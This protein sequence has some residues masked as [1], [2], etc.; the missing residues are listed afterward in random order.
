VTVLGGLARLCLASA[1]SIIA[2]H[3]LTYHLIKVLPDAA[4]RM[5]GLLGGHEPAIT[6]MRARLG[7]RSYSETLRGA[8]VGDFGVSVDGLSV[9]DAVGIQ[10]LETLPR[11]LTA[12][13]IVLVVMMAML[14]AARPKKLRAPLL[15]FLCLVPPYLHAFI[16]LIFVAL[17]GGSLDVAGA[18]SL[19]W[20]AVLAAAVAPSALLGAQAWSV[21]S[22][23]LASDHAV[24]ASSMGLGAWRI[25]MLLRHDAWVKLLP[26]LDRT[27]LWLFL[28]VN[29]AEIVLSL[30]GF[31]SSFA[32]ALRRSDVDMLL[33]QIVVLALL[34][35]IARIAAASLRALYGVQD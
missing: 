34:S 13:V 11:L 25:R 15:D 7:H 9:T 17:I 8:L 18:G 28:S 14:V 6:A 31:G 1:A 22:Q 12:S 30:P 2:T 19:W 21:M 3:A 16:A 10:M 23:G 32:S 33:A 5:S 29:F 24:F 26:S 4:T 20:G 27:F 35:N